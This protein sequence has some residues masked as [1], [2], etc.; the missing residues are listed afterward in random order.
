MDMELICVHSCVNWSNSSIYFNGY[1]LPPT[2]HPS[3]QPFIHFPSCS[4]PFLFVSR[5]VS[6]NRRPD[7]Q[8]TSQ[9]VNHYSVTPLVPPKNSIISLN[10]GNYLGVVDD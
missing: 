1:H 6:Q 2:S 5:V 3:C 8:L 7:L 4:S 9:L 10:I